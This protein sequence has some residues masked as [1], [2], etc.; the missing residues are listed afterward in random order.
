MYKYR[1][2][3]TLKIEISELL[4]LFQEHARFSK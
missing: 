1:V 2:T 3:D 4:E